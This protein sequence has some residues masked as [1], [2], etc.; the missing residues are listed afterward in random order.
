MRFRVYEIPS[1]TI[2]PFEE[3]D[4]LFANPSVIP[5]KVLDG[6]D[7]LLKLQ[8][9]AWRDTKAGQPIH[10]GDIVQVKGKKTVGRYATVVVKSYRGFLTLMR[11]DTYLNDDSALTA[12]ND[13][14]GN[15][16]QADN[17]P[18]DFPDPVEGLRGSSDIV[19]A[20]SLDTM[21]PF[22]A[23]FDFNSMRWYQQGKE[24]ASSGFKW[25]PWPGVK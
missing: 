18:D 14:L 20:Y 23:W 10:E 15:I 12:I 5:T 3:V 6:S 8:E 11:N 2:I 13:V 21:E 25:M 9:R 19:L 1:N 17:E 22:I 7:K 16:M 4:E 24:I